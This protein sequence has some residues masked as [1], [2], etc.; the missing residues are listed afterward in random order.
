VGGCPGDAVPWVY[1]SCSGLKKIR[2]CLLSHG[3]FVRFDAWCKGWNL[4]AQLLS[5]SVVPF[6]SLCLCLCFLVLVLS[7]AYVFLF[8]RRIHSSCDCSLPALCPPPLHGPRA[9]P[10]LKE[11]LRKSEDTGSPG[12][13]DEI[14]DRRTVS[15]KHPRATHLWRIQGWLWL[16]TQGACIFHRLLMLL[17]H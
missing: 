17:R 14:L 13:S 12:P 5:H 10:R 1:P 3:S 2:R 7:C 8:Q 11:E 16:M 15:D 9:R 4:S 6:L